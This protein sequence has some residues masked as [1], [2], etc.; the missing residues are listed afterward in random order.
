MQFVA[1]VRR[2]TETFTEEEFAPLLE[3]EAERLR[4]LNASGKV[5]AAWSREDVLGAVLLLESENLRD[6]EAVVASLPLVQREMLEAQIIP[7][8][9]YRGFGPRS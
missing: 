3:P 1:I 4:A 2:R 9:A 8:R 6:A 5:R 7:M